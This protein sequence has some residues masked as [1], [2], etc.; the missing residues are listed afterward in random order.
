[1]TDPINEADLHAFVDNL[2][3]V[4]RRIAVEDHLARHPETAARVMADMRTRDALAAIGGLRLP[5]PATRVLKAARRLDRGLVWRR[6]GLRLRRAAAVALLIG[7]GW[8]AH[9][10]VGLF[11]IADSEASPTLPAFVDD[12]RHS[13]QT[14]LIRARMV[15]QPEAPDYDPAEI[16]AETGITLPALPAD[17]R[18]ADAQIFPSRFGHSVEIAVET[19]ALGRVSLFAAR[20]PSFAVI[21]PTAARSGA[22]VTVYWQTGEFVYALTGAGPEAGL[23]QAASRLNASFR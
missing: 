5:P 18:V 22:A 21:A 6:I 1:M 11:E 12:A 2:L 14:A 17:W 4:P 13:H 23:E 15:S 20:A 9:A 3:D 10:H 8:F 19:D 7:A 16:R